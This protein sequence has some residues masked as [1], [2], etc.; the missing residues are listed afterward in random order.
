M[1]A[2]THF[3]HVVAAFVSLIQLVGTTDSYVEFKSD[4]KD[5]MKSM[6]ESGATGARDCGVC[7]V[8]SEFFVTSEGNNNKREGRIKDRELKRRKMV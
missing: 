4:G 7:S 8:S 3:V 2:A 1:L 5:T 6:A